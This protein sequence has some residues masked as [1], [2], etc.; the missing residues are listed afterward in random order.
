MRTPD[1]VTAAVTRLDGGVTV[2]RVIVNEYNPDGSVHRHYD[3]TPEYIQSLLDKYVREG[4]WREGR[5]PV[6]WRI[7]PNDYPDTDRYF[8]DAWKDGDRG[9]P[10]VDMPKAREIHR[11]V[12]RRLRVPRLEALDADYMQADE[13]ADPQAKRSLAL[14]KQALRDVTADPRIDAAQTPE[15]LRAVIPEALRGE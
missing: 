7:V 8:R 1:V 9:K 5:V 6:S 2:L 13:R 4:C 10:D 3:P 12:L 11:G 15:E 14:Q